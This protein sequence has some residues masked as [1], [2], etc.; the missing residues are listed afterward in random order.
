MSVFLSGQIPAENTRTFISWTNK[1]K[2]NPRKTEE[3]QLQR[4]F[5]FPPKTNDLW[6]RF[7]EDIMH[8]SCCFSPTWDK[9]ATREQLQLERHELF[10]QFH[11]YVRWPNWHHCVETLT[12]FSPQLK[13]P[14]TFREIR[15]KIMHHHFSKQLPYC[16]VI[17]G[18]VAWCTIRAERAP[19]VGFFSFLLIW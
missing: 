6:A 18:M 1:K 19:P 13:R 17:P 9:T 10:K 5:L 11:M 2:K 12:I 14:L 7:C 4:C 3:L 8:Q 16:C 15:V